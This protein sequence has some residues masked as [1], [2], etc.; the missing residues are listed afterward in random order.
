MSQLL[1]AFGIDWHLL[2]AQAVNFGIVLIALWYFLYKPVLAMLA[3]RQELVAK[4]VEDAGRA[5]EML[6]GADSE[7][8]SRITAA[9]GEA[10]GIVAAARET[11]T[12]EKTRLLQEAEERAAAVARDAEA[13]AAE[14]AAKAKRESEREVARLAILAVEKILKKNYD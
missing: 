1:S 5:S 11:A 13:R 14:T 3:K 7:A 8:N 4:G 12:A 9:E 6:A 10:E 2:L